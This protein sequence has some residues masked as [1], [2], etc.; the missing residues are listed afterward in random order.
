MVPPQI[1]RFVKRRA[2]F[3][4][5]YCRIRGW[6]LTVDHIL[7]RAAWR[8]ST[9][10]ADPDDLD[11]LAAAC[12]ECNVIGWSRTTCR[13]CR[14]SSTPANIRPGRRKRGPERPGAAA[15]RDRDDLEDGPARANNGSGPGDR[16][17]TGRSCGG[18]RCR[19]AGW[20]DARGGGCCGACAT[21][22]GFAFSTDGA[23]A[24][25]CIAR[26]RAGADRAGAVVG[27]ELPHSR[28]TGVPIRCHAGP[29]GR[30]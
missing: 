3:R 22:H 29:L 5:E 16:Q 12:W 1:W 18:D 27:A 6:P 20:R 15:D 10:P 21:G 25:P 2:R 19:R 24:L 23:G 11:N 13:E 7:P 14:A 30:E 9:S 26:E 4:C 28:A 17:C 8:G